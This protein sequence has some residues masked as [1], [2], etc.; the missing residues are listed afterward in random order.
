MKSLT[1]LLFSLFISFNIKAVTISGISIPD[2]VS[3]TDQSTKLILNG[4][5]IRSK[6]FFDIYIGSLYLE[7]KHHTAQDIYNAHGEKR[8]SMY[9]LSKK[10]TKNKLVADWNDGFENNH[11]KAELLKLQSQI[12]QFNRL[13]IDV[14]KSDIINLNFIPT[15]GTFVIINEK[16]M[17]LVEGDNFFTALLKIW[18]GDDPLDSDLKKSMLSK[19]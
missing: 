1:F 3:H 11:S 17:G 7:K 13:F 19:K 15:T 5:G 4:A 16:T 2:T 6:F 12:D 14:K 10:I 8:I 9:F 18:L